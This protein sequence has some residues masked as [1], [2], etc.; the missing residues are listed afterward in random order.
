[1]VVEHGSLAA[2]ARE[3]GQ[4]LQ[5]GA[6]DR[7]LQF[8]SPGFDVLA[9][10]LFPVWLAGGAVVFPPRRP[11]EQRADLAELAGREHVSVMELPA[12]YWHEWVRELDRAGRALPS[13][14][15]LVIV[16]SERVLPERLAMW[17]KLGVPL[18][19]VYGVTEATCSST[20][21][22]LPAGAGDDDLRHLPIGTPLPSVG[23]RILDEGLVPVP[24][25]AVGEL[26]ISGVGVARGY[27]GRPGLTAGRFVADPDPSRPGQRLYRTGD[28]VRQRADGNLEFLSRADAQIKIRGYRIEPAEVESALCR[29]PQVAQAVVTAYEPGPGERRLA[30]YIVAPPRTRP[31][32]TDLRRFLGRQLPDYLVPAAYVRLEALPL[33]SNGKID[34]DRLPEPGDERPELEE[35]LILPATPLERQLAEIFAAV[36]GITVVGVNDNFFELGGDSILA[37]QV[38][39]RAQE[40]GIAVAPLDLFEHPTLTLLAQKA[41]EAKD[42]AAAQDPAG[43][44]QAAAGEQADAAAQAPAAAADFPLARVDQG[45]LNT[46]LSRLSGGEAE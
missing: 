21:F 41:A 35:E 15:R 8:A 24:A 36:L 20:F 3:V 18:M 13:S 16:G 1:V 42:T 39:A 28:L 40:Q 9:E 27:L 7:F 22:R 2:F 29:H 44:A 14:L 33:T 4:R 26:Y 31:N 46:L 12:A 32:I 5:L 17:R 19:N 38:A 37:I 6:G 11:G 30:A 10:E 23:L 25:G 34:Y 45:Q 43:A